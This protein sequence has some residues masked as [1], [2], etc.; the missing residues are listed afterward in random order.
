MTR[1]PPRSGP[2]VRVLVLAL[3]LVAATWLAASLRDVRLQEQGIRLLQ[4]RPP[5]P[6]PATARRADAARGARGSR[7]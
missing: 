1:D 2:L 7:T 6:R 4:Q 5:R 3:A